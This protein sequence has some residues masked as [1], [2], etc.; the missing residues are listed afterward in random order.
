[1]S[2]TAEINDTIAARHLLQHPFYQDWMAGKLTRG[3]LSR[4]AGQY[5]P[6][7]QDFPRF[8]SAVHSLCDDPAGRKL[9]LENLIDEEGANGSLPHPEL[10]RQFGAAFGCDTS[11]VT[12][13]QVGPA[14]RTLVDTFHRLCRSSFAEGLAAL[15]AY[16]YQV[17]EIAAAKIEGLL[18][19]Y[20]IEKGPATSFFDVH[21]SADVYHSEAIA[22][23]L[24]GLDGEA[25][26][27]ALRAS[28][29]ASQA[30]WDFLTEVHGKHE[31]AA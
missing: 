28:R 30:L 31:C 25:R 3:D 6:H 21:Q 17:P 26:E 16:E 22:Q 11:A 8:V 1:M 14:A 20:G 19:F 23:L 18:K 9:L 29:E 2:V 5:A 13:E 15:Y 7:V 10:W 24:N 12:R 4:Y 27:R